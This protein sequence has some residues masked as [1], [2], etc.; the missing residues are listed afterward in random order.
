[1]LDKISLDAAW[2]QQHPSEFIKIKSTWRNKAT[3]R[4]Y[5]ALSIQEFPGTFSKGYEDFLYLIELKDENLEISYVPAHTF[6]DYYTS[7]DF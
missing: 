1:M 3:K 6:L 5:R 7:I 2:K 4:L